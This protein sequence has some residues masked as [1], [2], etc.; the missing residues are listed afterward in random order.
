MPYCRSCGWMRRSPA[1]RREI[2]GARIGYTYRENWRFLDAVPAVWDEVEEGRAVII[3]EQLSRRAGLGVGE[4]L[5]LSPGLSLPVAG[6]FGDYGNPIGQAIIARDA[7]PSG[8]PRHRAE[9]LRRAHRRTCRAC[10]AR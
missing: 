4:M 3:N 2:F 1:C 7:V 9:P 10:G 6:V 8:F 5:A